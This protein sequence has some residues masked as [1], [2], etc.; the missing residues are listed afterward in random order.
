MSEERLLD[1]ALEI[2][3]ESGADKA[4]GYILSNRG[5]LDEHSGQLY[6]FLYCLSA[7]IGAKDESLAWMREAVID[8]G[9]WYRPEVFEDSDLDSIRG[10]ALFLE[11]KKIS[12]ERYCE[13]L[14]AAETICTWNEAKRTKLALALHGNQQNIGSDKGFWRFLEDEGYQVEYVQSKIID[15]HMLYRWEDDGETQLDGIIR[16]IPWN[17]YEARALCGFSAGCNEILK[18]LLADTNIKCEKIILHSPWMP[19]IDNNLDKL[20]AALDKVKIEI[21]CGENDSDCLPHAKKL[22][23][24]AAARGL[25]CKLEIVAGLGHSLESAAVHGAYN[26]I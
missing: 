11:C 21:V 16:K 19:V 7:V 8:K 10:E 13:A 3:K 9:Y 20:M 5:M 22:A 23:K 24:E 1:K 12:D 25:N 6:N 15:S 14:R 2:L 4:Y 18:T 17:K 26:K